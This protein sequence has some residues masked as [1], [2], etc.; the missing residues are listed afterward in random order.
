VE[1]QKLTMMIGMRRF[2]Q[3]TN[4]FSGKVEKLAAAV[5]PHFMY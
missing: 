2:T 5:S 3:L 4:A 1:R